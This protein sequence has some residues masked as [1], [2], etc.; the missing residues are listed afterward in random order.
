M[1]N[2]LPVGKTQ[3]QGW[4]IG[5]RRTL[6]FTARQLWEIVVT[7]PGLSFW[8]SDDDDIVFYK[9]AVLE[10]SQD[11]AA[12]VVGFKKGELVRLRW[13]PAGVDF[14]SILQVRVIPS[15]KN[16]VLAFHHERL[17]NNEQREDMKEHWTDV[18]DQFEELANGS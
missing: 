8:F 3:Y 13:Q 18:I 9:G 11:T 10:T 14:P 2:D 12:E 15:G 4:E 5:V 6:P 7:Q 17:Q 16:A 1:D